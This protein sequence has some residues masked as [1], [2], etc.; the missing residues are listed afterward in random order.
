VVVEP[1]R[2]FLIGRA[3]LDF[4]FEIVALHA[5]ETEKHVIEGTIE[6]IFANVA[7]QQRATFV[8]GAAQNDVAA[9]AH[10]RAARRFLRKILAPDLCVHAQ[11]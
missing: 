6:M 11:S 9:N 3:F 10:P 1:V 7:A 4:R 2:H 5:L 8:V